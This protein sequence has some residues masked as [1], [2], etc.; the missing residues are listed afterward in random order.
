MDEARQRQRVDAGFAGVFAER[1]LAEGDEA[2]DL[3]QVGRRGEAV[4]AEVAGEASVR[5]EGEGVLADHA[6][7]GLA[8][9]AAGG[10]SESAPGPV[11]GVGGGEA[12][13]EFAEAGFDFGDGGRVEPGVGAGHGVAVGEGAREGE[14]VDVGGVIAVRADLVLV[15]PA[16]FAVEARGVGVRGDGLVPEERDAGLDPVEAGGMVGEHG[17]DVV[18]EVPGVEDPGL[19]GARVEGGD[20]VRELDELEVASLLLE[21][22]RADPEDFGDDAAEAA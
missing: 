4:L 12:P 19:G 15:E 21:G 10:V 22:R 20:P 14:P 5:D 6:P 2:R 3:V 11:D 7:E 17:G 8:L 1:L 9:E 18:G 13:V 16:E